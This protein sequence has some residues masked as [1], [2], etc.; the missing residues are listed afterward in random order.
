MSDRHDGCANG[1]AEG[2][3]ARGQVGNGR[4]QGA[5]RTAIIAM[6][7]YIEEQLVNVD[8]VASRLVRRARRRLKP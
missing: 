6:L 2:N 5:S 4:T 3:G 8:S 7:V 1:V